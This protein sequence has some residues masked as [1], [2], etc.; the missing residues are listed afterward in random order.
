L[1]DKSTRNQRKLL[2]E[3]ICLSTT[4]K[5][6]Q[7]RGDLPYAR[8]TPVHVEGIRDEKFDKPGA[9]NNRVKGAPPV[10]QMGDRQAPR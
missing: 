5:S 10:V 9:A 4:P 6:G 2:L 8:L 7:R 3:D 1:L